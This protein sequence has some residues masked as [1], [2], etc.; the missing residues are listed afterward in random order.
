[1]VSIA[2]VLDH[3]LEFKAHFAPEF[4]QIEIPLPHLIDIGDCVPNFCD[5]RVK[6]SLDDQR[7]T[8]RGQSFSRRSKVCVMPASN[9]PTYFS[10]PA[11]ALVRRGC[12]VSFVFSF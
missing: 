3:E 2:F 1:M 9:P 11:V 4:F 12:M 7:L 6:S 8:F 10:A 5:R